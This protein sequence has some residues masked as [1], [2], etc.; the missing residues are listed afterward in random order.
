MTV[1]PKY[2]SDTTFEQWEILEKYLPKKHRRGRPP[3]DRRRII[4][5]ILYLVRC[6]CQ[7]RMLP[8][9]FP[10]WN[11]VYGVFRRWRIEGVWE[12]INAALVR[13]V[14]KAHG[15]RPKPSIAIVDS[16]SIRTSEGGE[17]RGFDAGKKITGRK[18]NIGVDSL[19]LLHA[20]VVTGAYWQDYD[21]A[22]FVFGKLRESNRKFK[23]AF[24]DGA[25]AR[26]ELPAWLKKTYGIELETVER[27]RDAK[28][29]VV[30]AKR[31]LVERTFAWI[32][33]HR[34]N[35]K[36][37]E[38][39]VDTSESMIYIAMSALMLK[40]LEKMSGK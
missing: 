12:R 22:C 38:R 24:A 33:R 39:L 32:V 13:L 26:N 7:W 8:K 2:P 23:K 18:R 35:A 14:R 27:R 15:K 11:T 29:F 25:Y 9:C 10:H 40:R 37:Y 21:A 20:V 17:E 5:A 31:W 6:G 36:D 28:G 30:L 4:D 16:Q 34:R 19:G 1:T 3:I